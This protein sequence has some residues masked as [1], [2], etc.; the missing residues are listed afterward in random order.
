METVIHL[1]SYR[2]LCKRLTD[3]IIGKK[4][5]GRSPTHKQFIQLENHLLHRAP[6]PARKKGR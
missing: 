3:S 4:T 5:E 1:L 2:P 6:N